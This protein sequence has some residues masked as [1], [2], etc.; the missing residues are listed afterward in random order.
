VDCYVVDLAPQYEL[1][2]GIDFMKSHQAQITFDSNGATVAVKK[3]SG[4]V[5]ELPAPPKLAS[6]GVEQPVERVMLSALQ[7]K[8]ALRKGA[9][10]FLVQVERIEDKPTTVQ[11]VD[12]SGLIPE[13]ELKA[14]LNEFRTS[15][16]SATGLPDVNEVPPAGPLDFE[17]IPTLPGTTPPYRKQYR[18][19]PA[20]RKELENR[21]KD[22]L[23]KGMIEP[24]TSPYSAPILF[25]KKPSGGLRMVL[26]YRALNK[27]TVK[28]R[29]P[30]PRI[31]DL[32]DGLHGVT[33]TSLLDLSSGYHQ[34]H[35]CEADK[36]KTA[37]STPMGHFQWRVLPQGISNAP[38]AFQATM[39][40]LFRRMIGKSVF[41]YM[42]DILVARKSPED[43]KE[44]L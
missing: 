43:H 21:I 4:T 20:E 15:V 36:P 22:L 28:N 26:D 7:L 9:Q 25:V 37:F 41:I 2:L 39:N 40:K 32:L 24:S 44:H 27:L 34:L 14:L 3:G 5:V 33:V 42:D 23:S 11:V 19:T 35:L 1:L 38:S 12:N 6:E 29:A 8:R 30:L 17:V 10:C 13:L 16:F 18:L 31:D